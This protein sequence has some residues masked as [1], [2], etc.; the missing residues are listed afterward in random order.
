M[1]NRAVRSQTTQQNFAIFRVMLRLRAEVTITRRG[2]QEFSPN[3]YKNLR[4]SISSGGGA[5]VEQ[6]VQCGP[7]AALPAAPPPPRKAHEGA[8]SR[9][10]IRHPRVP[11]PAPP[12]GA[13][14]PQ[15]PLPA[16]QQ[17]TSRVSNPAVRRSR[18]SL[19]CVRRFARSFFAA[20]R[21][22]SAAGMVVRTVPP[23]PPPLIDVTGQVFARPLVER[24]MGKKE[25][26]MGSL[27]V[28]GAL[29]LLISACLALFFC[30]TKRR[31]K[32][33]RKCSDA[34]QRIRHESSDGDFSH[35]ASQLA[36]FLALKTPF[37]S[38]KA[39]GESSR[40][41]YL[42]WGP[43]WDTYLHVS[44]SR[45]TNGTF[46]E[47]GPTVDSSS[48]FQ[49]TRP[50]YGRSVSAPA[51]PG[52]LEGVCIPS[53]LPSPG[54][55]EGNVE[56]KAMLLSSA[57]PCEAV[58]VELKPNFTVPTKG[59]KNPDVKPY[60]KVSYTHGHS[61]VKHACTK[62]SKCTPVYYC[63]HTY[64]K[65]ST[66]TP[67]G[68]VKKFPRHTWME[69]P[70]ARP[71][72]DVTS[73]PPGCDPNVTNLTTDPSSSLTLQNNTRYKLFTLGASSPLTGKKLHV[74]YTSNK[75]RYLFSTRVDDRWVLALMKIL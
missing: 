22:R 48:L 18:P 31:G 36:G 5:L 69:S 44:G 8:R 13:P 34:S 72:N 47:N 45:W 24:N 33:Y 75:S 74:R 1:S 37:I 66:W 15:H 25:L 55:L 3:F 9:P 50:S 60:T 12:G 19:L 58:P 38:T 51:V 40:G 63:M 39:L 35:S 6:V 27:L 26:V 54:R 14:P 20:S 17:P 4:V 57:C 67:R 61:F 49:T 56:G 68:V 65:V 42:P 64:T 43:F 46:S 10:R 28:A 7:L 71:W 21:R 29:L 23:Q 70:F 59:Y 53:T 16:P 52:I 11:A 73:R 32:R 2:S 62:G 30:C 41:F